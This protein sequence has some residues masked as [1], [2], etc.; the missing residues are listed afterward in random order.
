M[1]RE[2]S[3]TKE[4]ILYDSIYMKLEQESK[5]PWGKSKLLWEKITIVIVSGGERRRAHREE[6]SK[7]FLA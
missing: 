1:L 3:N 4:H 2:M 5:L 7:S 6:T